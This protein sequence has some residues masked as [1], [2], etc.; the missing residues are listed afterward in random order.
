[1][2][3]PQTP[4]APAPL[5]AD[6]MRW[7]CDP[8]TL[9]FKSTAELEPQHGIIGQDAAVEALQFGL[10]TRAPGQ[11]V[12]VRGLTGTGR[13]TLVRRLLEEA[14]LECDVVWDRCF[15]RNFSQPDRPRLLALP[16]GQSPL[17]RTRID[18]L[19][20]FIRDDLESALN[21]RGLQSRVA[22]LDRAAQEECDGLV[23]PFEASLKESGL[24]LVT[25]QEDGESETAICPLID[26]K[27]VMPEKWNEMRSSG[28]LTDEDVE[29][30]QKKHASFQPEFRVLMQQIGEVQRRRTE[31]LRKVRADL[32]RAVLEEFVQ[33]I[34][35]DYHDTGVGAFLEEIVEDVATRQAHRAMRE[36]GYT[37]LY[38][39]NVVL[40]RSPGEGC[41]I[42]VEN[43]P[44]FSHLIGSIEK[45]HEGATH[46]Q[47]DHMMI[48]SG[49]LLRADG[50]FLILDAYDLLREPETWNALVRTLRSGELEIATPESMQAQGR[51]S[52]KPEPIAI[53]VKVVLIGSANTYQA[54]DQSDPD[55]PHLFK[56]LADFDSS[57]RRT[58]E[59]LR[60]YADVLAR[61]VVKEGLL[62]FENSA[63]A[64][65]AEHGARIAGRQDRLS[66]RFGRLGDI[67]QEAAFIAKKAGRASVFGDDVRS[68][69][70]RSKQR[71]NL[72]SKQ[73]QEMFADGTI[74]VATRGSIVGQL[75]GLAVSHA[76][77]LT[78]G[79]PTRIT[80]TIGPGSAGVINI[81]RESELSGAIH[82]KGFYILGGLLR[83]LLR[84]NHPLAFDASIAFEQTY[85][86]IDG[87][88]ASAAESCCLLSALTDIPLR[89]DLAI[90]GAVDQVGN[91][92][93]IGAAN[94]KIEGFFDICQ[95][96]GFTGTQGVIIPKA[97]ARELMLRHDVVEARRNEQFHIYTV[98]S[99]Y[100]ALE[101]LSGMPAG[102]RDENNS[103]PEGTLL[104]VAVSRA[105]DFWIRAVQTV[106]PFKWDPDDNPGCDD[107]TKA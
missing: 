87:D 37:N 95:A 98:D 20:D 35:K 7:H 9:G 81:E 63:V 18:D 19:A 60:R 22:E 94:E 65:V 24:S 13:K 89:Q 16:C 28:K 58:P 102:K 101:L 17:F 53:R 52:I 30:F 75:N 31:Q 23:K 36:E 82:T 90:T 56:V 97:N 79:F 2:N 100:G 39:V 104:G 80:A 34:T 78:F 26:D 91:I 73:F 44:T 66:T 40:T 54:L 11:N 21:V 96:S 27:P 67:A 62:E 6:E 64:A 74:R 5:S 71:A 76:G 83:Y 105:F 8:S 41:P 25:M 46:E 29:E 50:G 32:A 103:Y 33:N 85:G 43:T 38:R 84:T 51:P 70:R 4:Q 12:F 88:S 47:A 72:P 77:P 14:R 48:R 3:Q 106:E 59:T 93:A 45:V 55:F 15:V 61:I 1:M 86:G 69:V 68:A 99:I 49:S 92:M 57:I 10:E 107:E 42:I